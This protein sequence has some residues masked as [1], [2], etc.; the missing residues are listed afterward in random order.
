MSQDMVDTFLS[1]SWTM[2]GRS[3]GVPRG[4]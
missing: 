3:E 1:S 2:L 4:W